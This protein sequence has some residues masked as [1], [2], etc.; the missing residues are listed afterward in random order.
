[1]S[2]IDSPLQETRYEDREYFTERYKT[3][4]DGIFVL[5]IRPMKT[6]VFK[7][8]KNRLAKF[9]FKEPPTP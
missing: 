6:I 4:S 9:F 7:D 1:M 8:A 3:S 2:K 5:Y